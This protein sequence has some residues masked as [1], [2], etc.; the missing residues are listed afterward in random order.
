MGPPDRLGR[1]WRLG[2]LLG[3]MG[4]TG[5][6]GAAFQN[7]QLLAL[8]EALAIL[9][10]VSY[11]SCRW[12]ARGVRVERVAP[13]RAFEDDGVETVLKVRVVGWG[14]APVLAVEDR[15]TADGLG[16]RVTWLQAVRGGDPVREVRERWACERGRG[17]FALGPVQV[18]VSDPLGLFRVVRDVGAQAELLVYPRPTRLVGLRLDA[19]LRGASSGT[20]EVSRSGSS[21]NFYGLREYR[22]GEPARR[23]HWRASARRDRLVVT[24][25]E[26]P[27]H[28]ALTVFLDL[29][30]R[31][32][33]GTGRGSTVEQAIR[34]AAAIGCYGL[35]R[36]HAVRLVADDGAPRV[37]EARSGPAQRL[38]LLDLL[39]Q[40]Q[41][42]GED[43]YD[44]LVERGLPLVRDGG[45]VVLIFNGA[46]VDPAR[47]GA[48]CAVWRQ[49]GA[50]ALGLVLDARAFRS[51]SEPE[52][53]AGER[54]EVV[55]TT[56]G[57]R[58]R[59]LRGEADLQE[60]VA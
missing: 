45:L 59:V 52:Q 17:R 56:L 11:A 30:R 42:R 48:L 5:L 35:E 34:L 21:T 54:P 58:H 9:L 38:A 12:G 39:A 15:C 3:F 6:V 36:G 1:A 31:T 29:D 41:P 4:F 53:S 28:E 26:A 57:V 20:A 51:L 40:V 27:T 7:P 8:S 47:W 37:L 13:D 55:L 22:P 14:A 23:I 60:E 49:R 19:E 10:A 44:L 16:R 32:L 46:P 18:S 2:T 33:R 25:Y 50:R 24:E 43:P